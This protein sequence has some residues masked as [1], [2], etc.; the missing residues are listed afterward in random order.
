MVL[1]V[2]AAWKSST[3]QALRAPASTAAR[4]Q[5]A[6][7]WAWLMPGSKASASAAAPRREGEGKTFMPPSSQPWD[8]L[9]CK[10][11][12]VLTRAA[13]VLS[14]NQRAVTVLVWV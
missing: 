4:S 12:V 8:G 9:Q 14:S 6:P 13:V 10:L 11:M 2:S 3:A 1:A 7:A 5:A